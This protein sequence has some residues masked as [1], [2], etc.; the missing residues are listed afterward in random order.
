VN[1][2]NGADPLRDLGLALDVAE[3]LHMESE[4]S[5]ILLATVGELALLIPKKKK[6]D[7]ILRRRLGNLI[8]A[9]RS[10]EEVEAWFPIIDACAKQAMRR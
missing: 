10:A 4:R 8:I 7:K 1:P 2:V 5:M 3:A 6:R 9:G